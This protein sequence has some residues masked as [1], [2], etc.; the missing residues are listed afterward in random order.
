MIREKD[1]WPASTPSRFCP[2]W[3]ATVIVPALLV[4]ARATAQEASPGQQDELRQRLERAET[5]IAV[6]EELVRR[7]AEQLETLRAS[8]APSA[9]TAVLPTPAPSAPETKVVVA[10]Q[11]APELPVTHQSRA[12]KF[13]G[14][15]QVW[16]AA[17]DQGFNDTFRIRRTELYLSGDITKK[18]R[19]QVMV[20]PSKSLA[21]DV[22]TTSVSGTPVLTSVAPTQSTREL[23]NAFLTFDLAKKLQLNAGQFK[24]PLSLEGLQSSGKLDTVERALFL[25]DRA[26]GGNYGDVRDI[27][28]MILG[29]AGPQVDFQA[30]IF[31]GL[32]E[33]QNELDR[34]NQ[35]AF[36][37]RLVGRPVGDLQL[38]LSGARGN[39]ALRRDRL[40]A[41]L[42]FVRGPLRLKSEFVTGHDGSLH[43]R[44]L[45]GHAGYRFWPKVETVFRVDGWDPDTDSE[46]TQAS[47]SELDYIAGVNVFLSRHNLKLQLEYLRK[48]FG[49]DALPSRN[50]LLLNTQT[51]W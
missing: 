38:G 3:L 19:W 28:L 50:V 39:G 15:V 30:G 16:Y 5:R 45:Y 9:P 14:L 48:T 43:R 37:G 46:A 6:L 2:R 24:L 27:G 26:R 41:E 10:G 40:E 18:A 23:Q 44:G 36:A 7:Q 34:N 12:V 35:K 33:S 51:F 22:G 31:N 29:A 17:A 21:L 25:S 32:A 20:D 1:R 13:N 49:S 47:V 8:A 4:T 42:Q 11:A